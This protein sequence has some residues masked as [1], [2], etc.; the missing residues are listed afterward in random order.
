MKKQKGD[1]MAARIEVV[2]QELK[3]FKQETIARLK[4]LDNKASYTNGKIAKAITDIELLKEK[5]DSCSARI[6]FNNPTRKD[7]VDLN[8]KKITI[9]I[10]GTALIVSILNF[11]L[12]RL[13]K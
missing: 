8:M 13:I 4:E 11:A 12:S 10:T 9:I 6:Y 3:D 5:H 7:E 2:L 1:D